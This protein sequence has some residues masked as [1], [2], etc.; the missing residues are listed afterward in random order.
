MLLIHPY[1]IVACVLAIIAFVI[2]V[3]VQAQGIFRDRAIGLSY[4]GCKYTRG[5]ALTLRQELPFRITLIAGIKYHINDPTTDTRFPDDEELDPNKIASEYPE[6]A[7]YRYYAHDTRQRLGYKFGIERSFPLRI[8][9]YTELF[10]YYD[11]QLTKLRNQ[12]MDYWHYRFDTLPGPEYH[13]Y[14]EKGMADYGVYNCIDQHLGLGARFAVS[15]HCAVTLQAGV[16]SFN[17]DGPIGLVELY[18]G[19]FVDLRQKKWHFSQM[20]GVGFECKVGRLW[21]DRKPKAKN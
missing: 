2:P 18:P 7:I 8:L 20:W 1:R 17:T 4:N 9:R 12:V 16:G 19:A 15:K 6:A 10:V 5:V 11:V 13:L 21:E 14:S 3:S